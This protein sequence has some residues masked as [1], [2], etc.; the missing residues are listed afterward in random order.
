MGNDLNIP[1]DNL[2]FTFLFKRFEVLSITDDEF[3]AL[4]KIFIKTMFGDQIDAT[5]LAKINHIAESH[6]N[7]FPGRWIKNRL[8]AFAASGS[9]ATDV[10][11][12][13]WKEPNTHIVIDRLQRFLPN[14]KYIHV[15]RNGL[16]IAHSKNQAQ[17]GLWGQH[18]LGTAYN[19]SPNY[20][21]K[22]WCH[23]H[24]R[25][26]ALAE[27]MRDRLLWVKFDDLC[28]EPEKGIKQILEFL[29]IEITCNRFETLVRLINVPQ[30]IGRF[31]KYGTDIFDPADVGFVRRLG[32][33]TTVD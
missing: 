7:V 17:P 33:D 22:Y 20:S 28:L 6:K 27:S 14:M 25:V 10:K 12:W 1:N 21:L 30:S 19:G 29:N 9:T 5:E 15:V 18:F 13:G 11:N 24:R 26:L 3:E 4:L 32:F 8:S 31:K 16:D 23:A 2:L